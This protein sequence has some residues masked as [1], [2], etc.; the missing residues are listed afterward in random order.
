MFSGL[1]EANDAILMQILSFVQRRGFL[2]IRIMYFALE[3]ITDLSPSM[4][5]GACS[6]KSTQ[7]VC[8]NKWNQG[9]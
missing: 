7:F 6:R 4:T 3:M 8:R 2:T 9:G 5:S 1:V